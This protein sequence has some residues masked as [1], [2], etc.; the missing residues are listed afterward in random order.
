M[1]IPTG[2]TDAVTTPGRHVTPMTADG[3]PDLPDDAAALADAEAIAGRR[4]RVLAALRDHASGIARSLAILRGGDYGR[5][6]F[7]TDAGSWTLSYEA[8]DVDY[9]RFEPRSGP[10][11]Y[12]LTSREPPSADRLADALAD[13]PAFVE[14]VDRDVAAAERLLADVS[15]DFPAAASTADLAAERDRI[16]ARI[17]ET[18]DAMAA[19]LARVDGE[20]G[21]FATTIAGTRWE[22]KWEGDRASYLRVGGADGTYLLSQYGPPAPRDLRRHVDDVPAFVEAFNEHVDALEVEL[23]GVSLGGD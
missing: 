23:D 13:Y 11:T 7:E 15:T 14:A 5:E 4:E 19:Q 8:G 6:T 18:A 20:Y 21:T 22:L 3:A 9:L 16:C 1:T 10:E 12:V 17:R 2:S